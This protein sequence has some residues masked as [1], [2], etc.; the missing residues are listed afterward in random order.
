MKQTDLDGSKR[1]GESG[2]QQALK[3]LC[4]MEEF[5]CVA[6][7]KHDIVRGPLVKSWIE[8]SEEVV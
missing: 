2:M 3:I 1:M 4:G 5:D 7:T 6:F 8:A